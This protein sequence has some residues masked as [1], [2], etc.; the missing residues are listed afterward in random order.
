MCSTSVAAALHYAGL[1]L[2]KSRAMRGLS[3]RWAQKGVYE[4]RSEHGSMRTPV[5][6]LI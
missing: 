6:R 2:K 1:D 4:R 3:D 5:S